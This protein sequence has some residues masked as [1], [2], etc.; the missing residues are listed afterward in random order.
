MGYHNASSGRQKINN[1]HNN[2]KKAPVHEAGRHSKKPSYNQEKIELSKNK[3][4]K[5]VT[6]PDD[7]CDKTPYKDEKESKHFKNKK[8]IE[9]F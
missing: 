9:R 8:S 2:V 6:R 3:S 5:S 4:F 7:E 1:F